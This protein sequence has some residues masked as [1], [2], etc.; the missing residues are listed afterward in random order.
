MKND[1][2][3]TARI[4]NIERRK[5]RVWNRIVTTLS[6]VVVFC[7]TYA[8]ILPAIT[9][10]SEKRLVCSSEELVG[11]VHLDACWDDHS[12]LL[13]G[14][15]G[16]V[17]HEHDEN[18]LDKNGELICT[19]PVIQEHLH[20]ESC[21]NLWMESVDSSETIDEI[22]VHDESC[23]LW[24][25]EFICGQEEAEAHIHGESC[26]GEDGEL[27]C[28]LNEND[29]HLHI[30]DCKESIPEKLICE[31][32]CSTP[33]NAKPDDDIASEY[34]D[35]EPKLVC[36]KEEIRSH[37]HGSDCFDEFGNW[38]CGQL[39]VFRH[40]HTEACFET[41][42]A[43]TEE[44]IPE[45]PAPAATDSNAEHLNPE[46]GYYSMTHKGEDYSVSV[47]YTQ[48]AELP[49]NV[50]L[51]V[52][53]I[54]PEDSSYEEYLQQTNTLLSEGEQGLVFCRFFDVSFISEGIEV[55]PAAS[56]EV[57]VTYTESLPQ[58][59]NVLCNVVHFAEDGVEI[60]PAEI[61][62]NTDGED[63]FVFSQDSFSVVGT[64]ISALNLS[65]GSYI[66]YK[67][68]YAI[69]AN[70]Y[71]L[72][73]IAI[74][75]DEN[76]YVYPTDSDIPI[77][78]ITWTY[79]ASGLQNKY[80]GVYMSL[81]SSGA[82]VSYYSSNI[83]ALIINN[84]VRFSA[85][86]WDYYYNTVT[87]HL[88]LVG[89]TY[90]AGTEFED[91]DYFLA[92][93]IAEVDDT[94]IQPGVLEIDDQIKQ[95]GCLYPKLNVSV[96][97]GDT[98]K[99]IWYRSDDGSR[100]TEVVR[101]RVTG[102]SYNVAA[103]G[104][105]LNVALDKGA[106]AKYKVAL[107][108][109][110]GT[111]CEPID[112]QEYH[113]PYFDSLR[114]GSFEAPAISTNAS[115][116]QPF[117]PNGTAGMVWKTTANDGEVEFISVASEEF[118]EL[119]TNW[120][121]CESASDGVQYVELNANMAGALYQ[122]VLTVPNSTMYWSLAHRGRGKSGVA[123]GGSVSGYA[124]KDTMYVIVMPTTAAEEADIK[125]Q[126]Q[127][128]DIL[129]NP[130][131]YPD[132]DVVKITDDSMAWYY[133]TGVY[134][135]PADQYL[136][137]YFFVAGPTYFDTSGDTSAAAYTVGNHLDDVHFST[138]L[139]PPANG[140]A[141]LI[142]EKNVVGLDEDAAKTLLSQLLFTV[143]GVVVSGSE[144]SNFT[145]SGV[146]SFTASYQLQLDLGHGE[147]VTKT[148]QELLETAKIAGYDRIET[149]VT[150]D[151]VSF[152]SGEPV[153]I[154][155][156]N[157]GTGVVSYTNR[158]VE[159]TVSLDLLKTDSNGQPLPDAVFSLEMLDGTDRCTITDEICMDENGTATLSGLRYDKLYRLTE[160]KAP[161]G[162][163]MLIS[164]VY[165]KFLLADGETALYPC[166]ASGNQISSWPSQ[167]SLMTG[168]VIGLQII[169]QQ[170]LILPETGGIG[171]ERIYL[172]G[173]CLIF[174]SVIFA[175]LARRKHKKG[176]TE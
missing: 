121:N 30:D 144:F 33:S 67:D 3:Q 91:G 127:V 102:D 1:I 135:V 175:G 70:S 131:K 86:I 44:P 22:H 26:F 155:I 47:F 79:T 48:E 85:S 116:Y 13:C 137:R 110:N 174:Y 60:L 115:D 66:F 106:D 17:I 39:Q 122:D 160:T 152:D 170:G 98:L 57:R 38:V 4:S 164:P 69:G 104:S 14:Y 24:I 19:F 113:I 15:A 80:Y 142:I 133:H 93:K 166:D 82:S 46:S 75:V 29:G 146:D 41:V 162:Y 27:I 83:D 128:I 119:S 87:Y 124:M 118:K 168:N 37:Q 90:T 73:S 157:K 88:G 32:E 81:T 78:V 140:Y 153:Q 53:E 103:D 8:L 31:E 42:D 16:F 23:Y 136:T 173:F 50:A 62:V 2:L 72:T 49:E 84:A 171:T 6:C 159:Q 163:Y 161:D 51:D 7:T 56:V 52:R 147:S 97:A 76:G 176:G 68:G 101:T 96:D 143:D 95:S 132:A 18:C 61:Q 89:R 129:N 154:T 36:D 74:T 130:S 141:N 28:G 126:D 151:D 107:V 158:Y 63:T 108:A 105:W 64:T 149:T 139:P 94:V 134:V 145:Q 156:W 138:E 40:Q 77:S 111:Q 43:I 114:N 100:W 120:H 123:G 35:A 11:H 117:L 172:V 150:A 71:G 65:E 59:E 99:Y 9:M 10:D 148:I 58:D 34:H 125:T 21:F 109:I 167:V 12:A 20:D 54:L 92:A 45:E 169:N 165:F 55:E 25:E 5:K 112:S